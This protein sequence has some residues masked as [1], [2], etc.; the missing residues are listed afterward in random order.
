VNWAKALGER[1]RASADPVRTERRIELIVVLLA[2]LLILQLVHGAF[3]LAIISI[4]EAVAPTADS[5]HV[6]ISIGQ[7][8]VT[9]ELNNEIRSRPLLW[10]ARRPGSPVSVDAT[11]PAIAKQHELNEIKLLGVFGAGDTVGIIARVKDKTQRI[12]LGEVVAGWTLKAVEKTGAV[13]AAG[14]RQ[15]TLM[16]LPEQIKQS[17]KTKK[18]RETGG[19]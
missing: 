14:S 10:P 3:R 19:D 2:L 5:M 16:L 13:F 11:A 18:R 4:P 7:G 9:P 1:Y 8:I 6:V 12:R 15:K 17:E